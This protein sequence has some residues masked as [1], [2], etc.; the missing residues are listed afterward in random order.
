[1]KQIVEWEKTALVLAI[2]WQDYPWTPS[3]NKSGNY[4]SIY[5]AQSTLRQ[6]LI[7]VTSGVQIE[8]RFLAS[9]RLPIG[10]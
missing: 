4:Q 5:L 9:R 2:R 10:D 6:T 7:L 3:E 8:K 1:M